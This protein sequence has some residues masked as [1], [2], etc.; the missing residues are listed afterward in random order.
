MKYNDELFNISSE[1][2]S[3]IDKEAV[4]NVDERT[5][6]LERELLA[7]LLKI[8]RESLND[9]TIKQNGLLKIKFCSTMA[10]GYSQIEELIKLGRFDS[11]AN[12]YCLYLGNIEK[13]EDENL[14]SYYEIVWDYR[15]YF[16]ILSMYEIE[17]GI[18]VKEGNTYNQ[19]EMLKAISLF[20]NL[21]IK[22]QLSVIKSFVSKVKR[23][24]ALEKREAVEAEC[25][26]KG[27]DY[28]EWKKITYSSVE[29]NPYLGLRDYI[30]PEGKEYISVEHTKWERT[31]DRCGY[32]ET[33]EQEP[34][35]LIDER[36][37]ENKQAKIKKLEK[38]LK[39]LKGE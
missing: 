38:E 15:T 12:Q 3:K 11:F 31:C 34:Q 27:H 14:D 6:C 35:E 20:R 37:E 17:K 22:Y 7:V 19:S 25:V 30:V 8:V 24:S 21:P 10:D 13:S 29:R 28:S 2:Y 18:D 9:G 23:E 5:T 33:V 16:E 26:S 32:V 4:D 36:N 1:Y 39:L